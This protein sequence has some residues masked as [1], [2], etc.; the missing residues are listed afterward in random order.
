MACG[1]PTP[2]FTKYLRAA[3]RLVT[4]RGDGYTITVQFHRAYPSPSDYSIAYNI[5]Y[6]TIQGNELEEG[7]K[8]VTNNIP[9][10]SADIIDFTPG[11]T[12]YFVVRATEY[13][14]LWYNINLLPQDPAQTDGYLHVYPETLLISDIDDS[15][16]VIP[17][18]DIDIFPSYGVIQIGYEL[19]RYTSI[20]IPNSSLIISDRGFLGT[21]A[22]LHTTSGYD[23]YK[24]LDPIVKFWKGYEEEN[25]FVIQEQASFDYPNGVYTLADG[26]RVSD[27]LDTLYTDLTV[28]DDERSDFPRY[29]QVGWRRTDP[30][31]LFQGKCLDSYIGGENYCADGYNGVNQQIRNVSIYEQAD[32]LQEFLLEQLGTGETCVLLRRMWEGITCSCVKINQEIPD[33]RCPSC[34]GTGFIT[35]YEQYINP[36]RSDSRILVRFSP[37]PESVK[38]EE[39][40][41]DPDATFDCWTLT[42]PTLRDRDVI[43][44]FNPDGTEEFRYEILDV[45]KNRLLYSET[46]NQHFKARKIRKTSMIYQWRAIRST[47]DLPEVITTTV[48]LLRGPN[49][50]PIPHTHTIVINEGI[51][52]LS[53]IN[54]TTSVSSGHDHPI[55]N[56]QISSVLGHSHIITL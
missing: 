23:G 3:L 53:Q 11:D 41:L 45:T 2:Y 46:G 47:A 13:D 21:N 39:A 31:L 56:G 24:T 52:S 20:D 14:P 44:R 32:R 1:N 28:N 43:I 15:Q 30:K 16:L 6:S 25:T 42:Y 51:L 37:T 36:R 40:G 26:Y 34:F 48:G 22:R 18:A 10:F 54:Q 7:P 19:L 49:N 38:L 35:G 12:Y 33:A 55:I 17:I 5:Y 27:K 4:S 9:G 29:D 8:F 50:V